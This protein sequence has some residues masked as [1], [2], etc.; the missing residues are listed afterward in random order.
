[1]NNPAA[2]TRRTV[3]GSLA[4]ATAGAMATTTGGDIASAADSGGKDTVQA[5]KVLTVS[6]GKRLIA[7]GIARMP[8][9]QNASEEGHAHHRQG[10]DNHLYRQGNPQD[11]RSA[12]G[13]RHRQG[14][15]RKGRRETQ[16]VRGHGRNRPRRRP[17][18][19][20]PL[21]GRGSQ[22]APARRRRPQ[23]RQRPGLRE[24]TRRRLD[25]RS[26]DH[27][28]ARRERSSPRPSAPRRT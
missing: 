14:L 24:Q 26:L 2:V 10:H 22:E 8:L 6:E 23:R 19:K 21:P 11:R 27:R 4:M 28:R 12:W 15:S 13:F 9:V 16:T 1:M 18:S 7:R 20:G 25:R 17:T 3:L 5:L